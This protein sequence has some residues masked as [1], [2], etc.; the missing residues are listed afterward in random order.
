M[1]FQKCICKCVQV[2]DIERKTIYSYDSY[3]GDQTSSQSPYTNVMARIGCVYIVHDCEVPYDLV[4]FFFCACREVLSLIY[5]EEGYLQ[6]PCSWR[7]QAKLVCIYVFARL[8][9][10]SKDTLL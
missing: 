7:M 8:C 6:N 2:F 9:L 5:K 10:Q 3:M 4:F 1:Y